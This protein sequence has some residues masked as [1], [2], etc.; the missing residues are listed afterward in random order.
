MDITCCIC[1]NSL[2][3]CKGDYAAVLKE[4][5]HCFHSGCITRWG[6]A[7]SWTCAM[8]RTS[9]NPTNMVRLY[10]NFEKERNETTVLKKE[11]L[12]FVLENELIK[13]NS[14][15]RAAGATDSLGSTLRKNYTQGDI[16]F[17]LFK[18]KLNLMQQQL[19]L[20]KRER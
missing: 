7:K 18:A 13:W 14:R 2:G 3:V 12:E 19:D 8:C 17:L 10:L 9:F 11:I 20:M 4:C 15:E 5:G 6:L 1:L 16:M